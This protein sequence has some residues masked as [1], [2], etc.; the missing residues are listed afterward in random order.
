MSYHQIVEPHHRLTFRDNTAMVAQQMQNPLRNAVTIVDAT[1][2]A[3]SVADL[4]G[5][6]DYIEGEDYS[7][8]NP[9]NPPRRS[10]RWL[11]RPN[12]IETG[13]YI[14]KEEKFDQAMDPTSM[15]TK[16]T[17]TTVERG[18]YDRILGIRKLATG[19]YAVSGGG[20]LGS[21]REGKTPGS[22]IDLPAANIIPADFGTPGTP[23]GLSAEKLREGVEAM[24]LEEFGLET[25]M[26]IYGLITPKQKTD[27]INLALATKTSL[28]PFDVENIREGKPGRLLGINWM[29]TN[30][31]P[32]NSAGQRMCPLWSKDNIV[33]G[34]WQDVEGD[35]WND[36]AAKNMPY[37]YA[38]A[39]VDAAR[40]EDG[41]VRVILCA[42]D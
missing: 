10:R 21:V 32:K 22:G 11:V 28:N 36:T 1:G 17:I 20:I 31:L 4:V 24:E 13:Q 12:V 29:F 18:V 39:Y 23:Y 16:N 14:T 27:L 25:E 40:V 7:R 15:L 41:G 30:R 9:D 37:I 3:Q 8:R 5:K 19:G 26:S 35:M 34:F 33:A 2:E 6:T 42:E 38:D